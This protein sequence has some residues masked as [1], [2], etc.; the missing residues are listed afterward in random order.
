MPDLFVASGQPKNKEESAAPETFWPKA[1]RPLDEDT[2][3]KPNIIPQDIKQKV[4]IFSSFRKNPN[5]FVF[6]NQ[7]DDEEVLLF[8][9]RHLVTNL[10]WVFITFIAVILPFFMFL[11]LKTFALYI[12]HLPTLYT[13]ILTFFYY[14]LVFSYAYVNF[15]SWSF[16]I[17]LI[18]TKRIVDIDFSEIVYHNVAVTKLNLIEDIDYSQVGFL[19]TLFDFGD[20]YVQTAGELPRFDFMA[21]PKPSLAVNILEDLIGKGSNAS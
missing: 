1:N 21:V 13:T 12:P 8:L 11:V 20:I 19:R 6:E 14:L 2:A 10:P 17:S 18:T 3:P 4:R 15:L 7:D 5:D 9:R 16:N